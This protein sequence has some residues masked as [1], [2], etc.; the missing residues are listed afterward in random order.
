MACTCNLATIEKECGRNAPGLKTI[1]YLACADD[2]TSIGAATGHVV[3]TITPVASQGFFP[4]NIIRQDNDLK[5]DPGDAGGFNT[6]L[7]GFVSKQ[8]AAKAAILTQLATDENYIA[9]TVDQ[10]GLVSILGS[11]DHPIKVKVAAAVTPKNGYTL[12]AMWEG[13][14]DLPLTYSGS[15]STILHP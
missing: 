10:N 9:L 8:S 11:L 1:I 3:S 13:H 14:A 5:S 4:I 12:T 15:L 6:E 2:I 7:K